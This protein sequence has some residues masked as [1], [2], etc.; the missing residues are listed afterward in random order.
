MNSYIDIHSHILYGIDDGSRSL[1]ESINIIKNMKNIGF[2]DII[3]TPHYIE[4][5]SYNC[6][7]FGKK[8]LFN[9]LKEKVNEAGIEINLY[10]GNEIFVFDK[11]K[12]FIE[13][14][15][16][17][18]LAESKYL[19]IE[20][21][22]QQEITN[23]DNCLFKL[24]S[25]GYKVIL[26]HPERYSYFQEDPEKIKKYI[27]MGIEFQSNYASITGRYGS[28]AI[29]TIKYF[30][31]HNY[32]TYLASDIHHENSDFYNDFDKMKKEII[33]LVGNDN[34][35][36]LSYINAKKIIDRL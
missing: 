4:G 27:D 7:N 5:T 34:F 21:P 3:I 15:E 29:K 24:I 25:Y 19:L 30:L 2:N 8:I 1:E 6:N 32:I 9:Y 12:E 23:L 35:A 20:T 11:I 18:A 28:H 17:E 26:A 33:H 31:K 10:L 36:K 13:N 16:I 22:M 14:G